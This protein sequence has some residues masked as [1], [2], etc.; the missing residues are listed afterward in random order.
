M[1]TP[2]ELRLTLRELPYLA[3]GARLLARKARADAEKQASP[4]IREDSMR[5]KRH[6][7]SWP[8]R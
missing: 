8:R 6:T 3:A 7:P 4:A 5:V 2:D 1:T